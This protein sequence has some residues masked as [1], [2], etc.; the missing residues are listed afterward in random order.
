M[1]PGGRHAHR[2]RR[3]LDRDR[4]RLQHPVRHSR[5]SGSPWQ[6]P[7]LTLECRAGAGVDEGRMHRRTSNSSGAGSGSGTAGCAR[8]WGWRRIPRAARARRSR[9]ASMN[10]IVSATVRAKPI[11]WVTQIMVM[12]SSRELD[13]DVQHLLDHLGIERRGR[14]VEQHHLRLHAERAGDGDALLLA[15]REL[16]GIFVRLLGNAHALEE[17]ASRAPRPRRASCLRTQIGAKVRFSSTV[18]CGKRLNCWNTMPTS[19]RIASICLA[20]PVSSMPSTRSGPADAPRA[21]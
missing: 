12:P 6:T 14:L 1:G 19:R 20:S 9:R 7:S 2:H 18:R 13:H 4:F 5:E 10:T 8:F 15:A 17:A 21:G 3:A 16:A 11:S